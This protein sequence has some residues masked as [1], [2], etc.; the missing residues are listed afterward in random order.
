MNSSKDTDMLWAFCVAAGHT[1]LP[2]TTWEQHR[3]RLNEHYEI[4]ESQLKAL[5][6]ALAVGRSVQKAAAIGQT[7][8]TGYQ[9]ED[10]VPAKVEDNGPIRID[11]TTHEVQPPFGDI[12]IQYQSLDPRVKRRYLREMQ[13]VRAASIE[14]YKPR[15]V[16]IYVDGQADEWNDKR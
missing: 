14:A 7:S 12:F 3:L 2:C 5:N 6:D 15:R 9:F 11:W 13:D 4:I 8:V 1:L 16:E 10:H